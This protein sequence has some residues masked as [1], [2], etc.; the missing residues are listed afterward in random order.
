MTTRARRIC[1]MLRHAFAHRKDLAYRI[2]LR[3]RR[4]VRRWRRWR[5]SKDILQDPL[6]AQHGRSA[7]RVGG[8]GEN[9]SLSKEPAPYAVVRQSDAAEVAAVHIR[10]AVMFCEPFIQEGVIGIQKIDDTAILF[11][12]A[13]KEQLSLAAEC[14][15]QVVIEVRE[16]PAIRTYSGQISQVQPLPRKIVFQRLRPRIGEHSTD[17]S[18]QCCRLVKFALNAEIE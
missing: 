10:N 1:S 4:H 13:S 8:H 18:F 9:T 3:Q 11:Y 5:R 14:L 7:V 15:A 6:A 2:F 16:L 12:D 17:L